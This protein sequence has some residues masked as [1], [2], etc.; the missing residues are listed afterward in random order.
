MRISDWSSDVCSSDLFSLSVPEAGVRTNVVGAPLESMAS[1][2]RA[3]LG[4]GPWLLFGKDSDGAQLRPR[5]LDDKQIAGG[6]H[7]LAATTRDRK[8]V[9][10][11]KSVSVRV[12]LGGRRYIKNK[13]YSKRQRGR[14]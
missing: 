5:V 6:D 12:N 9:V 1:E 7:G 2:L 8:T 13:P 10:E 11:G 4:S 14:E 3:E